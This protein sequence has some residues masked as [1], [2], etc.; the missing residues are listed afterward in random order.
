MYSIYLYSNNSFSRSN[1]QYSY[2]AGKSYTHLDGTFPICENTTYPRKKYQ[3]LKRA[4]TGGNIAIDK[5]GYVCGFDIEDNNGNVVYKSYEQIEEK[6]NPFAWNDTI[7]KLYEMKLDREEECR[8]IANRVRTGTFT[9]SDGYIRFD[10]SKGGC[11]TD[12]AMVLAFADSI[13]REV[14]GKTV[15]V[16]ISIEEI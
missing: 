2:W 10:D 6:K 1:S 3:S 13:F 14:E 12:C 9:M 4:I 16:R 7:Q 8:I 5:Y 11:T 15:K